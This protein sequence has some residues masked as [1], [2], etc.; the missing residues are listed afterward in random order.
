MDAA[1]DENGWAHL[2]GVSSNIV[3]HA[4]E[5]NPR[6]YGYAKLNELLAA[7]VLFEIDRRDQRILIKDGRN[8]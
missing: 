4:S 2:G 1:S 8:K 3:K 5:F 7:I 6:N